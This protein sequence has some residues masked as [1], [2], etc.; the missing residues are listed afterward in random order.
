MRTTAPAAPSRRRRSVTAVVASVLTGVISL[1]GCA[2]GPEDVDHAAS[3]DGLRVELGDLLMSGVMVL[4]AAE[5]QPGTVLGAVDNNGDHAVDVS[6]GLPDAPAPSF[7]VAPGETV[8]L[9]PEDHP[10]AVASV[11]AR[12]GATVEL[13]IAT[14]RYGSTTVPAPVLDGTF[15]RYADLVPSPTSGTQQAGGAPAASADAAPGS[16]D[17]N[18]VLVP[19]SG[20]TV[21]GPDVGVSGVGTAFEGNLRWRA[22]DRASGETTSEGFTTAGAN[23]VMGPFTF[24]VP[25]DP[26]T[27][28]VEV[29][30]P[31]MSEDG[32]APG[33]G[34]GV[35]DVAT[36]TFTVE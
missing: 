35:R 28:T 3:N 34:S 31:A 18:V 7:A 14:G 36:T 8:L 29:W 15:P 27:Y 20:S 33:S 23:G 12:P 11:P 13:V 6:I 2:L 16:F 32:A 21:A 10:V 1:V 24:T 9:G 25:L 26:G 22:T 30:E 17:H 4:S 5:G 19:E